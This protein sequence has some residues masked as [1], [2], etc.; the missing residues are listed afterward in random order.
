M[1]TF[2]YSI[3]NMTHLK[4]SN[5]NLTCNSSHQNLFN[6]SLLLSKI[7]QTFHLIEYGCHKNT[8]SWISK[9]LGVTWTSSEI[10]DER[11]RK[12]LLGSA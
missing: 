8:C 9:G 3:H 11:T 7:D 4:Q 5:N 2:S 1:Y 10:H 12:I 6:P